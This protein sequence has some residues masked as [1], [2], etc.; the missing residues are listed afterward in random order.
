MQKQEVQIIKPASHEE[1]LRLRAEGIGSSEVGAIMGL[2]PYET[3]LQLWRRR[4]GLDPAPQENLAM[5]L[6]H[7][8]EGA[9]A[10]LWEDATK[11]PIDKSTEGDWIARSVAAPWMQVSPDRLFTYN[12]EDGAPRQG[13]LECKTTQ[14]KIET[15]AI[16]AQWI[17]QLQYQLGVMGLERGA[18]A[19]LTA[20][21]EFGYQEFEFM[22]DLF[23][24]ITKEVETFYNVNINGNQA[25][26]AI[27]GADAKLLYP[28]E[29]PGMLREATDAG[30]E[31]YE[32]LVKVRGALKEL[33]EQ[34]AQLV[35]EL[36]TAMGAAEVLTYKGQKLA[37]WKAPKASKRFDS[38]A[39]KEAHPDMYESFTVET[40]ATR[41]FL[42]K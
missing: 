40:P 32:N 21:R 11:L 14:K 31:T 7:L 18:L 20:G 25:P 38:K 10:Q 9:V 30:F 24:T 41:R 16:P 28:K 36:Q 4:V 39:F 22:P 12:A 17:C 29:N 37:T 27:S 19:W 13:I 42:L 23:D 34:E 6:G 8:L 1:W 26:E 5:R 15:D 3:P 33:E 2:N 35:G